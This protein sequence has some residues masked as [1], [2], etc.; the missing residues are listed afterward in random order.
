MS[1]AEYMKLFHS[2]R[3]CIPVV[4]LLPELKRSVVKALSNPHNFIV[5]LLKITLVPWHWHVYQNPDR[6][7]QHNNAIYHQFQ[8]YLREKIILIFPINILNKNTDIFTKKLLQSNFLHNKK[9]LLKW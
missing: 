8:P 9:I 3:D 6:F 2:L 5:S 7:T 4:L 1:E